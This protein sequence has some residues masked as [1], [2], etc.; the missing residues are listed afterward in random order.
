LPVDITIVVCVLWENLGFYYYL[1][2]KHAW[3]KTYFREPQP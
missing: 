3:P 1:A 2:R